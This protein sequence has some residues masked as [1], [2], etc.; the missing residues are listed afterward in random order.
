MIISEYGSFFAL[1][2][3]GI[4]LFPVIFLGLYEKKIKY[5]GIL[6]SFFLVYSIVGARWKQFIVFLLAEYLLIYLYYWLKQRWHNEI[7]YYAILA[8]S[9]LPI[10]YTKSC[11][12]TGTKTIEFIGMSYLGFRIWQLIIE[13]HD[14]HVK[15]L[16]ILELFYFTTFFPTLSSGPIDRWQRFKDDL[17][18]FI[19]KEE[20]LTEYL[21]VGI[22]KICYGI[23]YKFALANCLN[24]FVLSKISTEVS[25]LS[26][27]EYMYV[28]TAYLFFD[29]AGYSYFAIGTGYLL[30]IKVPENFNKPFL[31]QN[32]KEFW[33]RWHM[34]LSRW[35]GDYIFS[36]FVLNS[37]R[38]GVFKSQKV[39]TRCGY[40]LTMLVMGLWHGFYF[41]Y[42]LYGLYQGL[43]LVSTD[44]YLKSKRYR[45]WKK[46]K[47]Y[48][49][50]SR[51]VCFHI[52][53]FGMLLFSGYIISF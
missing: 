17:D 49:L 52:A 25:L 41:Y 5:Y 50:I 6:V 45:T 3:F 31:A 7:F 14:N 42:F 43:A 9:V 22:K 39:A 53:A 21:I 48:V 19:S 47:H 46:S 30:G 40:I 27:L 4:C 24:V 15:K 37:L 2:V 10:V 29:F 20:Y 13:I 36:R 1:I 16:S 34:S 8:L 51:I 28:Y 23:C 38:S 26:S 44:I 18:R 32:M 12:L 11:H 33:E 35:F